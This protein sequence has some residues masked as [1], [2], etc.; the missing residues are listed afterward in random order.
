MYQTGD[1]V[2]I[3]PKESMDECPVFGQ[4]MELVGGYWIDGVLYGIEHIAPIPLTDEILEW[5]GWLEEAD[6]DYDCWYYTDPLCPME[7]ICI[8]KTNKDAD[9]YD[10]HNFRIHYVHEL[11]QAMRLWFACNAE[12]LTSEEYE[13]IIEKINNFKIR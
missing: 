5:N 6:D 4:I 1:W 2:N 3:T 10:F 8:V 11:Q 13:A 12:D 9:Y 7:S